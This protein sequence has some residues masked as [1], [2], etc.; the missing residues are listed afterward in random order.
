MSKAISVNLKRTTSTGSAGGQRNHDLRIGPQPRYVVAGRSHLNRILVEPLHASALRARAVERRAVSQPQRAMKSNASIAE[1]GVITFGKD[2]QETVRSDPDR[3]DRLYRAVADRIGAQ[4]GAEVTGLV[5]HEDETGPHA[6]FWLDSFDRNGKAISPR[7]GRSGSK[8]QDIATAAARQVIPEIERGRSKKARV[9]AGEDPAKLQHRSVAELH[10]DLGLAPGASANEVAEAVREKRNAE[11]AASAA[12]EELAQAQGQLTTTRQE[13]VQT[14]EQRDTARAGIAEIEQRWKP[15]LGLLSGSGRKDQ[16]Q[17]DHAFEASLREI[18]RGTASPGENEGKWTIHDKPRWDEINHTLHPGPLGWGSAI[19]GA[20]RKVAAVLGGEVL[21]N[22]RADLDTAAAERDEA[23]KERDEA[24][25]G[26]DRVPDLEETIR[27]TRIRRD[28]REAATARALIA[29]A[30]GRTT[31]VRTEGQW[32]MKMDPGWWASENHGLH[33]GPLGWGRTLWD[34]LH[35]AGQALLTA[36]NERDKAREELAAALPA[37]EA[38][39]LRRTSAHRLL[40]LGARSNSRKMIGQAIEEGADLNRKLG[41]GGTALHHAVVCR[42]PAAV[43]QLLEAGADPDVQD[44]NGQTPEE[45]ARAMESKVASP[46][47]RKLLEETLRV[48][49]PRDPDDSPSPGM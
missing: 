16:V 5:V 29:I 9:M 26:V 10:A 15:E 49:E 33:P 46:A 34:A 32:N 37:A 3:A 43:E 13:L 45:L 39:E 24:K 36:R 20:L 47:R 21:S 4:F 19:W 14:E 6:H 25:K 48:L 17:R 28:R 41:N 22:V 27:T 30:D 40:I 35:K 42:H 12:R 2:I 44:A 18:E 23:R 7:I 31:P 1:R 8:I 11:T 38:G